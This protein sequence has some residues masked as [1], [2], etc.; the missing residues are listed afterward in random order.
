MTL[1]HPALNRL[2]KEG[3]QQRVDEV[4][5]VG[6]VNDVY[7]AEAQWKCILYNVGHGPQVFGANVD[8]LRE[9]EP[10]HV[11]DHDD[12]GYLKP[13]ETTCETYRKGRM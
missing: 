3:S 1:T 7:L 5:E 10:C 9:R 4:E 8:E 13:C 11:D 6:L 2:G 12:A